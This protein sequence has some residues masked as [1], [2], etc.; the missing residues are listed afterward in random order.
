MATLIT[1]LRELSRTVML[2]YTWLF[3]GWIALNLIGF[4]VGTVGWYGNQLPVT[5][6]IWWIFVPDCPLVAGY[7]ALALWGI[8][9]GKK[10]TVFNL[11]TALGLIKYGIWTCL[12]WLL[13]WSATSDFNFLSVLMFFTHLGLI[14]QGVILLL[15]TERWKAVEALPAL[16]YYA[17]A[18][19]V[20]YGLGHHPAYPYGYVSDFIVQWHSVAVSWILGVL[21]IAL[22]WRMEERPTVSTPSSTPVKL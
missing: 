3:W 14:A 11:F 2:K 17:F 4:V 9:A 22:G 1:N 12:V 19:Y 8:R 10:W 21:F 20:D 15:L 16:V 6:L 18:D 7:F 13:Y 5:P